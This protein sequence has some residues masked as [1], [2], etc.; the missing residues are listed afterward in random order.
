MET[1]QNGG[2]SFCVITLHV[3]TFFLTIVFVMSAFTQKANIM[4]QKN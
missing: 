2:R 3:N 1:L 4:R